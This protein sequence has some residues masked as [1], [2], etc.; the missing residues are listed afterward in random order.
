[1][2]WD[3]HIEAGHLEDVERAALV[4]IFEEAL[5]DDPNDLDTLMYLANAY[6][7]D[8]RIADGLALDC[9]LAR[10]L[11]DE[12]TV[13]YNLACSYALLGEPDKA[14][15]ALEESVRKGYREPEH[16]RM[17]QDLDALRDDPRFQTILKCLEAEN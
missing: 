4:P 15:G 16:M 7:R 14:I 6:T 17:D 5:A 13:H 1:M 2:T 8:G 3:P 10:L 11:P 12:P 9:R